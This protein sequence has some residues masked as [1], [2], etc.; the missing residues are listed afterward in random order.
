MKT[1]RPLA[2]G[3]MA[4]AL[5]SITACGDDPEP[6]SKP[7]F[8]EQADAICARTQADV[9]PMWE[10]FWV[11]FEARF[12]S[13]SGDDTAAPEADAE[14]AWFPLF[15]ELLDDLAPILDQQVEDL[16]NLAPPTDD[17][18]LIDGLLDDLE[19]GIDEMNDIADRAADGDEA[20]REA[21]GSE[22]GDPLADVNRAA[23]E[24]GL[25]ACGAEE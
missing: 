24:Y 22:E 20:A 21:L 7:E 10:A 18:E 1:T 25:T 16:R 15:D 23:R 6:L 12:G 19:A 4:M 3:A 17:A 9:E 2:G 11:D 5:L 8:V 14:A 13:G